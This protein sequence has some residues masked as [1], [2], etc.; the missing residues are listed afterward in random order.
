MSTLP[1]KLPASLD[2]A[3]A[4]T[5]S[6]AQLTKAELVRRAVL[7]YL[8]RGGS[9]ESSNAAP[10]SALALAGDLVGCFA[11]GP[12]DLSSSPRH[13]DEFGKS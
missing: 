7:A 4:D 6:R 10:P 5:S 2:A 12:S 13:L 1:I 11:G 8:V 3:L 9:R